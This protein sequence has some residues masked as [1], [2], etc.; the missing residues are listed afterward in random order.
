MVQNILSKLEIIEEAIVKADSTT[1][2]TNFEVTKIKEKLAN[3][4]ATINNSIGNMIK[5][6]MMVFK[7]EQEQFLLEEQRMSKA[8]NEVG[9]LQGRVCSLVEEKTNLTKRI[10]SL[11]TSKAELENRLS[12]LE[13]E[14][15]TVQ[16]QRKQPIQR[17]APKQEQHQQNP[18]TLVQQQQEP[19]EYDFVFMCDSNRRYINRDE[20]CQVHGTNKHT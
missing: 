2:E 3:E 5:N 16:N 20:L 7:R 17:A 4:E 12:V 19:K 11:E 14:H 13:K 6:N 8:L 15:E 1:A 10:K 9:K 18:S